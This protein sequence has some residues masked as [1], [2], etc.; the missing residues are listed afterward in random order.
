MVTA[1]TQHKESG[2]NKKQVALIS[3]CTVYINYLNIKKLHLQKSKIDSGGKKL[4]LHVLTSSTGD[5]LQA[6]RHWC[7]QRK[8][9]KISCQPE[10][11]EYM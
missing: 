5:G 8:S 2:D 9:C 3:S 11:T 6:Q 1:N 10:N 7:H 4:L